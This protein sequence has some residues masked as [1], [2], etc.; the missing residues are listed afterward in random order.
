MDDNDPAIQQKFWKRRETTRNASQERVPEPGLSLTFNPFWLSPCRERTA[1]YLLIVG[2]NAA[3]CWHWTAFPFRYNKCWKHWSCV[4]IYF[5]FSLCVNPS[6]KLGYF[7]P[8]NL[9]R[10]KLGSE[11]KHLCHCVCTCA[12]LFSSIQYVYLYSFSLYTS[13]TK[14]IFTMIAPNETT[15][16]F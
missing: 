5:I 8:D 1:H 10:E 16:N 2:G 12:D 15:L 6:G 4:K 7:C 3:K 11:L 14:K 13:T 9:C